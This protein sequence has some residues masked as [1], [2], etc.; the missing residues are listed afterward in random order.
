M[1]EDPRNLLVI[2][3]TV[4]HFRIESPLGAGGMG[5]VW[6]AWDLELERRV[7]LKFMQPHLAADPGARQRF[8]REA[9]ALAALDHPAVGAVHG[10]EE[11]AGRPFMVL[12]FV[13]GQSLTA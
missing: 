1:P 6:L 5:E 10:V 11:D 2:G 8:V 7:A 9:R 4:G 12:A 3:R 13:E